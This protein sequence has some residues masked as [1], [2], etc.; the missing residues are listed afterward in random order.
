MLTK[1]LPDNGAV[2]LADVVCCMDILEHIEPNLLD[3]VLK[4]F[5]R[6]TKGLGFLLPIWVKQGRSL[7]MGGIRT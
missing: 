6:I 7:V 4:E 1:T 2:K 5:S 3:N